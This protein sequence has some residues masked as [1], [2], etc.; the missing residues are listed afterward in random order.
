MDSVEAAR[1]EATRAREKAKENLRKLMEAKKEAKEAHNAREQ[2][3][4]Q[5][6]RVRQMCQSAQRERDEAR[7]ALAASGL[8]AHVQEG[9]AEPGAQ[10]DASWTMAELSARLEE[11]EIERDALMETLSQL[12][13]SLGVD[14]QLSDYETR[15]E[16]LLHEN[17]ELRVRAGLTDADILLVY[18]SAQKRK[19]EQA[20]EAAMVQVVAN[21]KEK[22][23]ADVD[24][25]IVEAVK[26]ATSPLEETHAASI[27]EA[28]A[29]VKVE[30]VAEHS[31]AV[32]EAVSAVVAEA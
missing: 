21:S 32:K 18:P 3:E 4:Q 25:Q 26:S 6:E 24:S 10:E 1:D 16:E 13:S 9:E 29:A 14:Q 30:A 28:V 17:D 12:S 19:D 22:A 2:M 27:A 31:A 20:S 7:A 15:I 23:R 11:R 5:L 8:G